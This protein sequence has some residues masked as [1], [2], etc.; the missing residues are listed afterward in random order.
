M[1]GFFYDAIKGLNKEMKK[2]YLQGRLD[3]ST[4]VLTVIEFV[5]KID[6]Y[7][8]ASSRQHASQ[9]SKRQKLESTTQA[10]L[11]RHTSDSNRADIISM[12]P[13]E[14]FYHILSVLPTKQA[15]ATSVLSR[16]W[17]LLCTSVHYEYEYDHYDY[18]AMITRTRRS[19]PDSFLD[20]AN[21]VSSTILARNLHPSMHPPIRKFRLKYQPYNNFQSNAEK[22][23]AWVE[24][25][26]QQHIQNLDMELS[27][28]VSLSCHTLC[29]KTL[30]VL[31]L[32]R[33][34]LHACSS[35]EL[36]SLKS[37][38]LADV[39]FQQ[40]QHLMELLYGLPILEDL[41][42]RHIYTKLDVSSFKEEFKSLPKL[43]RA[44]L[45]SL[46]GWLDVP[47]QAIS[48]VESLTII[49]YGTFEMIPEFPNLTHLVFTFV[50]SWDF[51][52]E[53]LKNCPKL[54]DLELIFRGY[55]KGGP[56]SYPHFVPQCL[57]SHFT[58]CYLK[59]CCAT[60]SLLVSAFCYATSDF[61]ESSSDT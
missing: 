20:F 38:H 61:E 56:I 3:C 51:L 22:I 14:I 8:V 36:P 52:L 27:R 31:K 57:T 34:S 17:S 47:L 4:R 21:H 33:V 2:T 59:D 42:A 11:K 45:K 54:Q 53:M 1:N 15:I 19:K 44:E 58:K 28:A 48:N 35:V 16:R 10:I 50:D 26:T 5:G 9:E 30:V 7:D 13:D 6:T 23:N 12:L 24:G 43:V 41:K 25:L 40:P 46:R 37:L 60:E 32:T 55:P 49:K 29:C 39:D 18:K